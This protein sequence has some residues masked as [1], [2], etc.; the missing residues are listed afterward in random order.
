MCTRVEGRRERLFC[1]LGNGV[2]EYLS[3]ELG[4][5]YL[6]CGVELVN[7]RIWPLTEPDVVIKWLGCPTHDPTNQPVYGVICELSTAA[8][9]GQQ[10]VRLIFGSP[11]ENCLGDLSNIKERNSTAYT[12]VNKQRPCTVFTFEVLIFIKS[13]TVQLSR[14]KCLNDC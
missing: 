8:Q 2:G 12:C 11:L 4:V 14:S 9:V 5:L 1:F 6:H 10:Q 7:Q 13:L 3:Y